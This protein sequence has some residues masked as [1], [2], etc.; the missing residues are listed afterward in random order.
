MAAPTPPPLRTHGA[1]PKSRPG[2]TQDQFL[3]LRQQVQE[4]ERHIF[5][6]WQ[7]D[8]Y[9]DQDLH[10]FKA[11]QERRNMIQNEHNESQAESTA[12]H[13]RVHLEV[14][15]GH[16]HFINEFTRL[17][18]LQQERHVENEE[19]LAH[20]ELVVQSQ[21]SELAEQK[22]ELREVTS[23]NLEL[24]EH[25]PAIRH[26]E[27][28]TM[29]EMAGLRNQ[30]SRIE[31]EAHTATVLAGQTSL[32]MKTLTRQV[33]SLRQ[34]LQQ[35][36]QQQF[37]SQHQ[38]PPHHQQ[39]QHQQNLQHHSH[40]AHPSQTQQGPQGMRNFIPHQQQPHIQSHFQPQQFGFSPELVQQNQQQPCSGQ[41]SFQPQA[42]FQTDNQPQ[43]S[44]PSQPSRAQHV[45][46]SSSTSRNL[47]EAERMR[48]QE[49]NLERLMLKSFFKTQ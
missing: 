12:L 42:Q 28:T 38:N 43:H 9:L 27:A 49:Q 13:K 33:T 3:E 44:Q 10:N 17:E 36:T 20:L 7:S 14:I 16:S 25:G 46:N 26:F 32:S 11:E 5:E 29:Q 21:Q 22:H 18:E 40:S 37:Q 34:Q 41:G 45:S 31:T 23:Q 24:Q 8:L 30:S 39:Q 2:P 35:A 47:H 6:M 19:C 1:T 4:Q 15:E 48:Q